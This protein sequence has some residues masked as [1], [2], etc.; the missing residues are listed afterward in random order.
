MLACRLCGHRNRVLA[1]A[2]G[3]PRCRNCHGPLPWLVDA[4]DVDFAGVADAA[5]LPVLVDLWAPVCPH[6]PRVIR[7]MEQVADDLAGQV[8]VVK[9]NVQGAPQ[10]SRRF[11]VQASPTL[12]VME[13]GRLVACRCGPAPAHEILRWVEQVLIREHGTAPV[14]PTDARD[15]TQGALRARSAPTRD[16]GN[17][18]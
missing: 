18:G 6:G 5:A 16:P 3:L 9:V 14:L 1:G 2:L 8:K 11:S 15:A 13:R 12:L 17:T 4:T 10:L 7:V